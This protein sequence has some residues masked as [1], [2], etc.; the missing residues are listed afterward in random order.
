M[1]VNTPVIDRVST[2][3]GRVKLTPVVGEE[4]VYD[5]VRAD[6]PRVLGTLINK[7]LLDQKAYT[8][9]SNVTIYVNGSTGNDTTGTG[10][11]TAPYK[12]IQRAI[13]TIPKNLGGLSAVID[14]A[15]GT[16]D[17]VLS[18]DNFS[19][20]RLY[21]GAVDKAVTISGLSVSRSIDVVSYISNIKRTEKTSNFLIR[22]VHVGKVLINK[23]LVLDGGLGTGIS[24]LVAAHGGI[25]TSESGITLTI[26]NSE[27]TCIYS[28]FGG[29]IHLDS[30]AGTGNTGRGMYVDT[31]GVVSYKS[32]TLSAPL[33]NVTIA[34]GRIWT[35]T[36]T[37]APSGLTPASV[38]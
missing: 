20:G 25:L 4:N 24:C 22:V 7:A 31:G 17:E 11:S 14:I 28:F 26:N 10:E 3:P 2:Y 9:T 27:N 12:T 29:M 1:P 23:N 19:N 21:L 35:G 37:D 8:L 33:G 6:E 34:G 15:A 13:N 18:V 16:Y 5:M 36:Q 32:S 30:L 38:E